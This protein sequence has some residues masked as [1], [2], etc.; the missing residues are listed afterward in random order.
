M[1]PDP[2]RR[3]RLRLIGRAILVLLVAAAVVVTAVAVISHARSDGRSGAGVAAHATRA[4]APGRSL[5]PAAD[6]EAPGWMSLV[7]VRL[8]VSPTAGPRTTASGRAAGF[9]PTAVGA[10]YAALHLSLRASPEVGPAIFEPTFAGQVVGE[11]TAALLASVRAAYDQL[12]ATSTVHYGQP[13]GQVRAR[14]LGYRVDTLDSRVASVRLLMESADDSG[15]MV[16]TTCVVRLSWMHGDWVLVAP[17]GGDWAPMVAQV[18]SRS[19]FTP[20]PA[21]AV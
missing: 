6:G 3:R 21:P 19:G 14:P 15:A 16:L 7:G 1:P 10:A 5:P 13:A 4:A 20:F 17:P 12:Q 9:A 2:A 8:P 18:Y 11:G